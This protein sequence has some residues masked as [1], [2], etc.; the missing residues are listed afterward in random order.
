MPAVSPCHGR[1]W[2]KH[3]TWSDYLKG[4][5]Y[6]AWTRAEDFFREFAAHEH[7]T[8]GGHR[9]QTSRV[10]RIAASAQSR[11]V[12]G[13]PTSHYDKLFVLSIVTVTRSFRSFNGRPSPN[14]LSE[15]EDANA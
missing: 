4:A 9:M 2:N 10:A 6:E 5:H 1:P 3:S 11:V 13:M 7:W 8:L 15:L 12:A 14:P